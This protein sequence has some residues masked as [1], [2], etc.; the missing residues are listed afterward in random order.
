MNF[1]DLKEQYSSNSQNINDAIANV[2]NHGKYILGPEVFQL[3]DE[4][5]KYVNV[6]HCISCSSGT[7][8]LM[9]SL[10]SL[11]VSQHDIVFVPSFTFIST[12][13]VVSLLGA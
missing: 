11:G 8:G 10:M 7:D 1:I 3:E 2:L 13:E 4:L 5:K 6:K 12:A 9:M